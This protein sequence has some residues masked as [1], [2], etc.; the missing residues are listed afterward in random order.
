MTREK[1]SDIYP[2][3]P[4]IQCY[5]AEK[6]DGGGGTYAIIWNEQQFQTSDFDY[7]NDGM[8]KIN[9]T[10]IYL[11]NTIIGFQLTGTNVHKDVTLY[12]EINEDSDLDIYARGKLHCTG[13]ITDY[14]QVSFTRILFLKKGDSILLNYTVESESISISGNLNSLQL[15]YIPLGGFNNGQGGNIIDRGIRR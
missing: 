7:L 6:G 11:F 14:I 4:C 12:L 9:T 8:I 1:E 13:T 15:T 3:V 5:D 10:G 2:S